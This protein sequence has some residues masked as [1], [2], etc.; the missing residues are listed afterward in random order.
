MA[1]KIKTG[2]KETESRSIRFSVNL[3]ERINEAITG[4]DVSFSS[5][6][7][8]ACE[9]ALEHLDDT[10]EPFDETTEK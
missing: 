4:K 8:Q 5:F 3:I 10:D 6:V 1:F 9:Y 2:K 7:Q